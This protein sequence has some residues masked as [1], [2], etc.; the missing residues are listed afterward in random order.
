M[1]NIIAASVPA[2]IAAAGAIIA[3]L[4]SREGRPKHGDGDGDEA[5]SGEER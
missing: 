2:V 1:Q 4:I 3:A 5:E